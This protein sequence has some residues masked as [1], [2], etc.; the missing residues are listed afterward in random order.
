[1]VR[2]I[3]L[4]TAGSTAV[5]NKQLRSSG[6]IIIQNQELQFHLDP[7]PGSLNKAK[8]YGVNLQNTTAVLVSHNHLNHCNDI[9]LVIDAMTHSGIEHRGVVLG[10]KSLF[11]NLPD[12]YPFITK[13]HQN[14][15]EKAI[16]MEKNHKVAIELVEINALPT[17]HSD[18]TSVGFKFFFP[19]M[20]LSYTGDTILTPELLEGLAGSD[21]IIMNLPSAEK[22]GNYLHLDLE[23]VIKI[24]SQVKPQMVII[25][26][27]GM[28]MLKADPLNIA[29]E[30][31]R[32]TGV[33]TLAARDGMMISSFGKYASP[34]KGYP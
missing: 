27:F 8:E 20:T 29:R 21:L 15:V 19:K 16:P 10:S 4:G 7:G 24:V 28:E 13:Y 3:F 33:Q 1:M 32:V 14:L 23:S 17:E 26:H 22:R 31:Q 12:S 11:Q 25:T 5:A 34:V 6:G 9:N 30:I 18:P 2:V